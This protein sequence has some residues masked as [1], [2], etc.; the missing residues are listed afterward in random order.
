MF[1]SAAGSDC[2]L[3]PGRPMAAP[4]VAAVSCSEDTDTPGSRGGSRQREAGWE[5]VDERWKWG[6]RVEGIRVEPIPGSLV[7]VKCNSRQAP[8]DWY[9]PAR[10]CV[11]SSPGVREGHH[12]PTWVADGARVH[13]G[14][15][16]GDAGSRRQAHNLRQLPACSA[17]TR[18]AHGWAAWVADLQPLDAKII[19]L[20]IGCCSRR[21]AA[22]HP[23]HQRRAGQAGPPPPPPPPPRRPRPGGR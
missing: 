14:G 8:V 10:A 21:H 6:I 22:Q 2:T 9:A 17:V 1:H 4:I 20:L 13:I 18:G 16:E 5:G 7:H 12:V 15:C 19:R 3:L 11:L 23:T